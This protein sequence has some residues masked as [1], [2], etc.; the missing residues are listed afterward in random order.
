MRQPNQPD[1][2]WD[3]V[4]EV[5]VALSSSSV[6]PFSDAPSNV[7]AVEITV[8]TSTARLRFDGVAAT[9]TT[10]TR[11]TQGAY[12][13]ELTQRQLKKCRSIAESGSPTL[14]IQYWVQK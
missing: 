7:R 11:L 13:Y 6:S 10:G 4:P 2:S 5:G 9:T 3:T 8:E 12:W 14:R 1:P